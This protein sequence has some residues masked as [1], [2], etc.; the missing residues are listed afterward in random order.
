MAKLQ[1]PK[2]ALLNKSISKAKTSAVKLKSKQIAVEKNR[3]VQ[4]FVGRLKSKRGT[5]EKTIKEAV[6]EE[7]LDTTNFENGVRVLYEVHSK[8]SDKKKQLLDDVEE[9]IFLQIIGIKIPK[10]REN[11]IHIDLPH[12]YL[13]KDTEICFIS[14]DLPNTD[15]RDYDKATTHFENLLQSHRVT[16]IK[17]IMSFHQL[18]HEYQEFELK[19]KLVT[20]YN[21]FLADSKI[22]GK[23]VHFLGST[24]Y[25]AHK[26][27]RA[28]NF[29]KPDVR[30]QI[31]RVLSQTGLK[32]HEKGNSTG[33]QV[34]I[35]GMT[36]DQVLENVKA[37]AIKLATIY[38]GG[39]QN[40]RS[41]S[42]KTTK[43]MAVPLY[44][45]L[46]MKGEVDVPKISP[47]RLKK[48][49]SYT[50]DLSTLL[51]TKVT[52]LPSGFVKTSL[53]KKGDEGYQA[54][55]LG[56]AVSEEQQEKVE[57]SEA[58]N[59]EDETEDMAVDAKEETI[60][61]E[62]AQ[63]LENESSEE[64]V[65]P[66]QEDEVKAATPMSG[67]KNRKRRSRSK[68]K[69]SAEAELITPKAPETA[70]KTEKVSADRKKA[71][72]TPKVKQAN[73][74][75]TISQVDDSSRVGEETPRKTP[76]RN[77]RN[78]ISADTGSKKK[79]RVI[80][81]PFYKRNTPQ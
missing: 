42:I 63:E 9:P 10:C 36:P 24:F 17:T 50:D 38:P 80:K 35:I 13:P 44:L 66:L 25:K 19:R 22:Q 43:S 79:S 34:G 77:T 1:K 20:A 64:K 58:T 29:D 31:E 33:V 68:S 51:N 23:A 49:M 57:A 7:A 56:D 81:N 27:P 76:L 14:S 28:L 30:A 61:G 40:I 45:T 39:S 37:V 67:K 5:S 52:V 55:N 11:T 54:T 74:R 26:V 47:K 75:T 46:K 69:K 16:N 73:K 53:I 32:I 41:L 8:T 70:D 2:P 15:H 3:E 62:V 59:S 71:V 21:I 12:S 4:K 18:R 6:Q 60:H 78:S 65:E 72:D 48:N